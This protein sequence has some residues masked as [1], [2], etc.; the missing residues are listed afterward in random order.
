MLSLILF[1]SDGLLGSSSAIC[2]SYILSSL[3]LNRFILTSGIKFWGGLISV[4]FRSHYFLVPITSIEL[5]IG[6]RCSTYSRAISLVSIGGRFTS[7]F[8]AGYM[9]YLSLRLLNFGVLSTF[10]PLRD[11]SILR[12]IGIAFRLFSVFDWNNSL[13]SFL[14]ILISRGLKLCLK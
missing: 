11:N 3:L 1:L 12:L 5:K 9:A 2:A 7:S 8:V 4:K 13:E 14:L 6:F 10:L